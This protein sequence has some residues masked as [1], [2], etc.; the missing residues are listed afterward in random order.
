MLIFI[1]TLGLIGATLAAVHFF[2]I[3]SYIEASE[4]RSFYLLGLFFV[5][6]IL[7][8]APLLIFTLIKHK[9]KWKHFGFKKIGIWKTIKLIISGYLLYLGITFIITSIILY[10]DLKIPGYQ[11]QE[12]ILPLFGDSL[13][14]LV[15]AGVVI[16]AIAPFLEEIFFRGFLLRSFSNRWGIF[17]GSILSAAIFAIFHMQWQS[18]IPIFILGLIINSLVIKGKSLWPAIFFHAFNNA[19]AFTIEILI[20]KEVISIGDI[21]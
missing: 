13:T 8:A 6:W 9:L 21:V 10:T 12:R 11:I 20:L 4:Y 2:D 3:K 18:I 14:S 16:V 15:V 17:S 19:I 1:V 7:I 5:Q